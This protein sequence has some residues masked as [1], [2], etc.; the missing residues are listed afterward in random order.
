MFVLKKIIFIESILKIDWWLR[1]NEKFKLGN[2]RL[3]FPK[4]FTNLHTIDSILPA[5]KHKM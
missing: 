5:K 1:G 2:F 3:Y 4:Y